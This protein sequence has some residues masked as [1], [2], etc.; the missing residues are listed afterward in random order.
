M[1]VRNSL[2]TLICSSQGSVIFNLQLKSNAKRNKKLMNLHEHIYLKKD[3]YRFYTQ[4][5]F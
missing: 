4:P 5:Q 3:I 2:G 1:H